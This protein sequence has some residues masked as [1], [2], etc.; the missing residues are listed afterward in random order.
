MIP[1]FSLSAGSPFLA[2]PR[3]GNVRLYGPV[4]CKFKGR[5]TFNGLCLAVVSAFKADTIVI[6]AEFAGLQSAEISDQG[7]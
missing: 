6:K 1:R 4:N 3:R 5:K 7:E 2:E